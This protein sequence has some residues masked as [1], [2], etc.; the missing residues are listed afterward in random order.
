MRLRNIQWLPAR[1]WLGAQRVHIRPSRAGLAFAALL[2]ALWIAAVNYRLGLGYALTYFAAACAIADML[3]ASR[4]LAKLSL[5]ATP[6]QPVFAGSHARFTLR[7]INRSAR[8]RHAIRLAMPA[9]A[10]VLGAAEQLVDVAAHGASTVSI[11][12][13]APRRGWLLAPQLRLSSN[14]PLGLFHAWCHWL[15]EARVLVLP[16]PEPGA[17]PLPLPAGNGR[18]A[19]RSKQTQ[20]TKQ[21]QYQKH[22]QQQ[23]QQAQQTRQVPQAQHGR[24]ARD[25]APELGGVRAY[26]PGDPLQRLAWRQIAR[27]DGEHVFSKHFQPATDAHAG[28][29]L[30][31]IMLD[32]AALAALPAEA[33]LSR[34]AAWVLEAERSSVPYGL[35]LDT[36][37]MAP[38]LGT[39]HRD[40]CLRALAL[41]GL[42]ALNELDAL[43]AT[44]RSQTSQTGQTGQDAP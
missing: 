38:S 37:S 41:H 13:A 27:H 4:N 32:H 8:S 22:Q 35:R 30:G 26:Q 5:A 21:M 18:Q 7:L 23:Q 14:F 17:P 24:Q 16:R 39:S 1:P 20:Q 36:L 40:A 19:Q 6:G 28:A 9:A 12:V 33:R 25:G 43:P 42:P 11:E 10:T 29:G 44:P 3:F 2:L 31:S 34:L 15:P